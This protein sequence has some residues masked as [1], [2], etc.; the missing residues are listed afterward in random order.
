VAQDGQ[1]IA[2]YKLIKK[3]G[4]GG[5]GQVFLAEQLRLRRQVYQISHPGVPV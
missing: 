5:M 3:V 4:E 1:E 2:G